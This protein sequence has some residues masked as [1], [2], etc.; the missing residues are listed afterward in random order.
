MTEE[1]AKTKWCHVSMGSPLERLA[2]WANGAVVSEKIEL[3]RCLGSACMAWR[4]TRQ[5]FEV[6]SPGK[7]GG[8]PPRHDFVPADWVWQAGSAAEGEPSGWIE[9][10]SGYCGLAGEP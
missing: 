4:W 6:A 2:T 9:P 8:E 3:R 1:E 5:G 10:R 7:D